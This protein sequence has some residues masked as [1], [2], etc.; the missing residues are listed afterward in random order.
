MDEWE[1]MIDDAFEKATVE[2]GDFGDYMDD[3]FEE[4][5]SQEQE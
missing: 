4:L 5:T 2:G 1:D 3:F